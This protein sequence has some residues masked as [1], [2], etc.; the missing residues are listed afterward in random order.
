MFDAEEGEKCV[1]LA[2]VFRLDSLAQYLSSRDGFII[3]FPNE[4]DGIRQIQFLCVRLEGKDGRTTNRFRLIFPS[5]PISRK[6]W[7]RISSRY[8]RLI[9]T[10]ASSIYV[11]MFVYRRANMEYVRSLDRRCV[12]REKCLNFSLEFGPIVF[13]NE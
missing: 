13:F 9:G 1:L 10:F 4:R 2:F 11:C 12:L 5:Y 7:G 6:K 3:S 8:V